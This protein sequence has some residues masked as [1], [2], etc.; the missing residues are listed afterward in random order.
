MTGILP[1]HPRLFA[2]RLRFGSG[3]GAPLVVDSAYASTDILWRGSSRIK[4]F[5]PNRDSY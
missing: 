5:V 2:K 1:A 3:V 4:S